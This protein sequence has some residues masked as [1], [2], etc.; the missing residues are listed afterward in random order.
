VPTVDVVV[1]HIA[2]IA[3]DQGQ[4][5]MICGFELVDKTSIL[6]ATPF[7]FGAEIRVWQN[8]DARDLPHKGGTYRCTEL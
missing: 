7:S 1:I 3:D 4:F 8:E 6:Q 2:G 5:C